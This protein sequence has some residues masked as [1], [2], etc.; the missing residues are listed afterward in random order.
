VSCGIEDS[1]ADLVA[2]IGDYLDEGYLRIKIKIK[3]GWDAAACAAVRAEYPD[4]MLQADA[5][6]AYAPRG[7]GRRS[8]PSTPTTC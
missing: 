6:G 8:R 4:I 7:H 2:R 5:N 3:P 1:L